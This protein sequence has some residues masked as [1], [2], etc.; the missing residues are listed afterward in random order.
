MRFESGGVCG[1]LK[2]M[3]NAEPQRRKDAK[4]NEIDRAQ[5]IALCAS[6]PL[7]SSFLFLTLC[8]T[9]AGCRTA[10]VESPLPEKMMGNEPEAQLDFWHALPGRPVASNDEAFHALLLYVDGSDEAKDYGARVEA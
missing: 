3:L 10:R 6:A 4:I 7:R 5:L 2:Q 8:A 9:M 1:G